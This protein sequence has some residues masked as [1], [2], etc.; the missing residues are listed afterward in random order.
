MF[1]LSITKLTLNHKKNWLKTLILHTFRQKIQLKEIPEKDIK[2][3]KK[4]VDSIG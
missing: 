3:T 4:N 2:I 1:S